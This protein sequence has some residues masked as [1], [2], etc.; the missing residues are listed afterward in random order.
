MHTIY[1]NYRDVTLGEMLSL[2]RHWTGPAR[3]TL[4]AIAAAAAVLPELDDF[5]E[6]TAGLE[7]SMPETELATLDIRVTDSDATHDDLVGGIYDLLTALARLSHDEATATDLIT[8]RDHL[9][10]DG[11][12]IMN[13]SYLT[14]AAA[15]ESIFNRLTEADRALL[16]RIVLLEAASL[17]VEVE[18]L[19]TIG[20]ALRED[21]TKRAA[22]RQAVAEGVVPVSAELLKARNA[23]IRAAKFLRD[24]LDMARGVTAEQRQEILAKLDEAQ[25]N[26]AARALKRR[27][28][29][30]ASAPA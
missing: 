24:A 23:W 25:K 5:L 12:I 10:P 21:E 27:Q 8:L 26:A 2:A 7:K 6:T 11:K 17:E 28:A 13:A 9:F 19:R 30:I 14:E 22:L 29:R 20:V 1:T 3:A 18:A 4:V 15:A 16:R